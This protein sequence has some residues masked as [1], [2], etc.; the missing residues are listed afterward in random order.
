MDELFDGPAVVFDILGIP[1]TET[2]VNTWIVMA[3][4][5]GLAL[6][7]RREYQ[8]YPDKVQ[9]I[10]E[11]IVEGFSSLVSSTMGEKR[12]GFM[13]YM[14]TLFMFISFA[15]LL[16]LFGLR[17]PTADVNG[18][19]GLG[20]LTFFAIH[21]YGLKFKGLGHIKGLAQPFI[22]FLPLNII[23]EL[24]KPISLSFRLFGNI[25]GGAVIMALIG[26]AIS[27]FVPVLPSL[28]FELFTG[29]LQSFIFVMLTMVFITLAIE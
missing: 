11:T 16:G 3:V 14:V 18:T 1:I 22:L 26:G 15:N 19:L 7:L 4:L 28:Y 25:F 6:L 13:P 8:L 27:L 17:P 2:V 9:N 20:L 23:S 12:L 10:I 21:F 24:A 29:L 5:I